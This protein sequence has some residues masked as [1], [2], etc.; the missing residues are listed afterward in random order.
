MS[1]Y[2]VIF[3]LNLI[4]LVVGNFILFTAWRTTFLFWRVILLFLFF[5]ISSSRSILLSYHFMGEQMPPSDQTSFCTIKAIMILSSHSTLLFVVPFLLAISFWVV[6]RHSGLGK[7]NRLYK[8]GTI[9]LIVFNI[10]F[11]SYYIYKGG[12]GPVINGLCYI[13]DHT[14]RE[15]IIRFN[16]LS[17]GICLVMVLLFLIVYKTNKRLNQNALSLIYSSIYYALIPVL[18]TVVYIWNT[19]FQKGIHTSIQW[20]T[21]IIMAIGFAIFERFIATTRTQIPAKVLLSMN[22]PRN[23]FK[24]YLDRKGLRLE[25][26]LVQVYT[27]LVQGEANTIFVDDWIV[28]A[29]GTS[30]KSIKREEDSPENMRKIELK[31]EEQC[32]HFT[33]SNSFADVSE[34]FEQRT[35]LELNI[36]DSF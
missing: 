7:A 9:L 4:A 23:K 33:K 13:K 29:I 36:M 8:S 31:I 22:L 28:Q 6:L 30:G 5:N 12:I 35:E 32:S 15:E 34:F 26:E 17:S 11:C 1:L 18:S 10:L 27:K 14:I 25:Y 24:D 3:G 19:Y 20:I 2:T 21:P 16:W